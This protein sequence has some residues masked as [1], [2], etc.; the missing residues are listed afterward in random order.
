MIK[1][2][3]I[4]K[5]RPVNK[6]EGQRLV[7]R[8]WDYREM[9]LMLIPSLIYVF[10]FSYIPMY[11]IIIGFQNMRLGDAYGQSAWVGLYHLKRFF[12]GIWIES[13]LRNTLI[14]TAIGALLG[15]P[16][17]L[18]F[19]LLLHNSTNKYIKKIVQSLSYIPNLLSLV[20][21]VGILNLFVDREGGLINIVRQMMGLKNIDFFA[22]ID[23]FL[24]MYFISGI[25][26]ST[27]AGAIIFIGALAGVDEQM[28]EAARIDGASKWRIIWHIQLPSIKPTVVTMMIMSFG[29][30]FAVGADKVLLMQT[31]LNE[32][33]S[34][35]ISTYIYKSGI[36]GAQYSFTTAVG[37]FQ[38]VC[39]IAMLAI[40]NFIADKLTGMGIM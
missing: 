32:E 29:N 23:A 17:N 2:N 30:V 1:A 35:V 22:S 12:E 3:K 14:I 24:P 39:N 25:W 28:V 20:L 19:A 8:V 37:L 31:P 38:N 10:I 13:L 9:Y 16:F 18:G 5:T 36:V 6:T 15:I 7:K 27:G 40:V 21:I 33:I 26:Q 34:E 11:G 4:A